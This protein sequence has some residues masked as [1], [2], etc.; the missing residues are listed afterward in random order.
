MKR[1]F[2]LTLIT[3]LVLTGCSAKTDTAEFDEADQ[4]DER[5]LTKD[6]SNIELELYFY[7]NEEGCVPTT[8]LIPA[9]KI[10][11]AELIV[12]E[13]TAN[14]DEKVNVTDIEQKDDYVAIYFDSGSAPLIGV[15][16]TTEEAMLDCIAY[17]LI[18]N[19]DECD[20]IYFRT[21]K[22]DYKSDDIELG[23]DEPYLTR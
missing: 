12:S 7:N 5:I 16:K 3:M 10:I 4:G 15:S 2:I 22:G 1:L 13:V 9:D 14:F 21:D 8:S 6:G 18:D 20:K 23:Y 19:L 17:S 11:D